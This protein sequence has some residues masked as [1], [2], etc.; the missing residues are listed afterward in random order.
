M[1][2]GAPAEEFKIL[3][4]NFEYVRLNRGFTATNVRGGRLNC[5]MH[6][7][8]ETLKPAAAVLGEVLDAVFTDDT[9]RDLSDDELLGGLHVAA[10][11]V[12]RLEALIVVGAAEVAER[13]AMPVRDERLCTR[14]G[15]HD[16][17]ELLQRATRLSA[18]TVARYLRGSKA[19]SRE[20]ALTTGELLPALLPETRRVLVEGHIGLDGLL[21]IALPLLA[22]RDRVALEHILTAEAELAAI[23]RG[24]G[25]DQAPPACADE[26]KTHA[27]IWATYL[28]QDGAE[29]RDELAMRKRGIRLGAARDGVI[30]I[31]GALLPDVAGQF[32]RLCDSVMNP[33]VDPAITHGTWFSMDAEE[34]GVG[35]ETAA[36][37]G[38]T[39]E[40]PP[41]FDP[42]SRE[43]KMHDALA[44]FLS[45]AARSGQ[46]PTIGGAAPTL[47]VSVREHDL[48][49]GTGSAQ[50]D[51]CEEPIPA[52]VARHTAC[53]G[54]IQ[55]VVFD[56]EGRIVSL[57][58]LD[59]VFDHHQRKAIVLRDG[60]C[61]I[62]GCQVAAAWCEIHHIPDYADGGPTHSDHGVLLCWH[63]H[64]TL[65]TSRW[66]I[67]MNQGV[68]EVRGPA[69][70]DPYVRWRRVTKS[71]IRSLDRLEDQRRA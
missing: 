4:R 19:I 7:L 16:S 24:D 26:L 23:A 28:D 46:L 12:R 60:G 30:P 15:A 1:R 6:S 52:S 51:G 55:R 50:V 37:T 33:K 44:T 5:R 68:P 53:A 47:V 70:W 57:G 31:S 3:L 62:P 48:I 66:A 20:T 63:H 18:Q 54:R 8:T 39:G 40:L 65:D 45:V 17:N 14:M 34:P 27:Q 35:G 49:A 64:R 25:A 69:W 2:R 11:M 32:Q 61:V 59:R 41:P 71:P 10:A 13:S 9:L 29:P 36:V 22:M 56:R 43:Q 42:R 38:E 58:I 21:S 67:R